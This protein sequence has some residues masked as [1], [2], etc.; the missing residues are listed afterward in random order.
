[1]FT[2]EEEDLEKDINEIMMKICTRDEKTQN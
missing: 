2:G 1:M